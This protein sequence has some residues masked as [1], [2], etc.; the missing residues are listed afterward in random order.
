MA[1]LAKQN[2]VRIKLISYMII[3]LMMDIGIREIKGFSTE[4]AFSVT[5]P[6]Y[7]NTALSP[8]VCLE[9]FLVACCFLACVLALD[10]ETRPEQFLIMIFH[11]IIYSGTVIWSLYD[12]NDKIR[13]K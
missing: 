1:L 10:D 7:V 11:D 13:S 8:M 4:L 6:I 2:K 5:D 12:Y 9:I 3:G